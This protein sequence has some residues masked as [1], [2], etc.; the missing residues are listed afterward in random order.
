M[1]AVLERHNFPLPKK[2]GGG[3]GS[4]FKSVQNPTPDVTKSTSVI[5][6]IFFDLNEVIITPLPNWNYSCSAAAPQNVG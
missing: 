4:G 6:L 5:Y 1:V 2:K 3:E